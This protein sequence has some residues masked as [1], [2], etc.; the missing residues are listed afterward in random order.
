LFGELPSALNVAVPRRS[1]SATGTIRTGFAL[2]EFAGKR[3]C[4]AA[5]AAGAG[6]KHTTFAAP[7]S[8]N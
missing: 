7:R 2:F 8:A 4:K 5:T 6:S 3:L 1:A